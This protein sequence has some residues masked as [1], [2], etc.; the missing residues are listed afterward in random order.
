M[1]DLTTA[2]G[3]RATL[4]ELENGPGTTSM[5]RLIALSDTSRLTE[6]G[7]GVGVENGL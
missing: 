4:V 3:H 5:Q 1:V 6:G 2:Q 7:E